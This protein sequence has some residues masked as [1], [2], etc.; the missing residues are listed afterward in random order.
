MNIQF[1]VRYCWMLISSS[2][3]P[4]PWN[5]STFYVFWISSSKY[6]HS[7]SLGFSLSFSAFICS[8]FADAKWLC[9]HGF[10]YR[11]NTSLRLDNCILVQIRM[12]ST[13]FTMWVKWSATIQR[14]KPF[15]TRT[16]NLSNILSINS[17]SNVLNSGENF[18]KSR[19]K[20][21]VVKRDLWK[22]RFD[23]CFKFF[24]LILTFEK[25]SISTEWKQCSISIYLDLNWIDN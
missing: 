19:Q 11:A 25:P 23:F 22:K 2:C 17:F 15:Y 18:R 16:P 12:P 5:E 10:N 14:N 1:F 13:Q 8:L 21:M 3:V 9:Q 7:M 24:C 6:T 4:I 20:N